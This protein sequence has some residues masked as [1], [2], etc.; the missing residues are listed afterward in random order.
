VIAILNLGGRALRAI[1]DGRFTAFRCDVLS[2]VQNC[3]SWLG[4]RPGVTLPTYPKAPVDRE[5]AAR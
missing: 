3:W 1:F 2:Y 4:G 5:R